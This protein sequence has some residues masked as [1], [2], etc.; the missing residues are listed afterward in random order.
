VKK[1]AVKR[2]AVRPTNSET[3]KPFTAPVP[4]L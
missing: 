1:T 4:K 2:L 3:A